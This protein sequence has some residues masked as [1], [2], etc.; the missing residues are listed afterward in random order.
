MKI[1]LVTD[2]WHPQVNGVVTTW[3][4]VREQAQQAGHRFDVI[5]PGE[6]RTIA[7]PRYPEIRLA[8]CPGRRLAELMAT[9]E[10]QAVHVATEGPVG[11]AGRRWC[12]RNRVPFTTSYHTQFPQYLYRY[13]D[14]PTAP[15]YA[16]LRWFHG[17]AARTLVPTRSIAD[18]LTEHGFDDLVV[19]TRGVNTDLFHPRDKDIYDLPRPIFVYCGRVA[20]EKNIE[21]FCQLDVPGSRVVIGDGPA[22][23]ALAE[24]YP[25]VHF[26][27]MKKGD[28][29]AAH[30]AGGDVFVFPSTT[31]TFGVVM[32][33]ALA[34]GLPVAAYPVTGPI[35]VI[36]DPRVGVLEHDLSAAARAC[37]KLKAEDCI[38]FARQFTWQ[39]VAQMV[40]DN[41][42]PINAT[43][44]DAAAVMR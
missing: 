2:A 29:L 38:A 44:T 25:D 34:C 15:T 1:V 31:D 33:E 21:A 16:F 35:D 36:T 32:L 27:G 43:A 37:L 20:T 18:E 5:H 13:F 24:Q 17:P 9:Y 26:V 7:A 14:I 4:H 23:A 42:E 41:L 30:V 6:F 8:L 19:W 11:L 12:R 10:P 3:T 22:R 40:V 28:E 39:R